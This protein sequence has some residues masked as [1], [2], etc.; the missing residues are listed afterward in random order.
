MKILL[1]A[2]SYDHIAPPLQIFFRRNVESSI[3]PTTSNIL[4]RNAES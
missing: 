4:R 2:P 1:E 3:S